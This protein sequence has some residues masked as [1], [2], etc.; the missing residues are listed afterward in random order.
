MKRRSLLD[1]FAILAWIQDEP[2]AQDVEDLLLGAERQG[3]QHLLHE[4]NLAEVYYV[5]IRRTGEAQARAI[6]D[7]LETLPLRVISTTPQIL[8]RAALLKAE[9]PFSLADAFAT[10][11][12]LE[13]GAAIV[14]GDPEF[15]AVAH[16]VEIH[17]I[18]PRAQHRGRRP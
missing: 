18:G 6:A 1:S 16:L 9:Y 17:W 2:G 4:V 3:E 8:W 13:L 11:T 15:E 5:T 12:A 10:G 7:Q 14:T